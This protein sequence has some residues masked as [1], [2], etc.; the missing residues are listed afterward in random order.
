M[1]VDYYTC[2]NCERNFP[3]CSYHFTCSGCE[4]MF[5]SDECGGRAVE[6]KSERGKWDDLTS[7]VLCRMETAT[8]DGLLNFLL[9]HFNLTR[10]QAME[11]YRKVNL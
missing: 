6:E 5:C 7:C 2:Q 10:D 8:S 1:G 4:V 3:D 11:L 9:K